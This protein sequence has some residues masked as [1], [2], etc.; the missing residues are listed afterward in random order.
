MTTRIVTYEHRYKRPPRKRKSVALDV[1]A[2]VQRDDIRPD[3][4][5]I[6]TTTGRKRAKLQRAALWVEQDDDPEVAAQIDAFFARMI[7]PPDG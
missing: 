2:V 5:A 6:V 7:R 1:P 4:P 3:Q